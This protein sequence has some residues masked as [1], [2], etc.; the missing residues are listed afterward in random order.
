MRLTKKRVAGV[1]AKCLLLLLRILVLD[2]TVTNILF[3]THPVGGGITGTTND[4]IYGSRQGP[5]VHENVAEP[6][7][8]AGA[9]RVAVCLSGHVRSFVHPIVHMSIRRNLVDAMREDGCEVDVFAYASSGDTVSSVKK[10]M[11]KKESP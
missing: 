4:I 5:K 6:E 2:T 1:I 10:V 8:L 9:C 7:R 11:T 3:L